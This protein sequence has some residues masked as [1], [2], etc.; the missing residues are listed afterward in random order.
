MRDVGKTKVLEDAEACVVEADAVVSLSPLVRLC[1]HD[2]LEQS[3]EEK[4][5]EHCR[6]K[7]RVC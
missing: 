6:R 2:E 4:W 5:V 1:C 3:V 7:G